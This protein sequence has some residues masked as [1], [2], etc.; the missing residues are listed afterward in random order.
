MY[1]QRLSLSS[2]LGGLF[3]RGVDSAP[4]LREN[5][6][7][8][9]CPVPCLRHSLYVG[10]THCFEQAMDWCLL[11]EGEYKLYHSVWEPPIICLAWKISPS[12]SCYV[13]NES[14]PLKMQFISISKSSSG[15][16]TNP[17]FPLRR[18]YLFTF[19]VESSSSY[20][21]A[22]LGEHHYHLHVLLLVYIEY[23]WISFA[24]NYNV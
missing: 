10:G 9:G 18:A 22:P 13:G 24:M 12:L 14:I 6:W 4:H 1:Q 8:S 23:D 19:Y 11:V 15:T 5:G 17:W 16:S 7:S 21:K 2:V 20:W 3:S